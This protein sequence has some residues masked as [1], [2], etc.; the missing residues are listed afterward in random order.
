[1]LLFGVPES[2]LSQPRNFLGKGC[3]CA[4]VRM[5]W[6]GVSAH[7]DYLHA[8]GLSPASAQQFRWDPACPLDPAYIDASELRTN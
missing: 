3:V 6:G 7:I 5:F 8:T 1:M 4:C 2:K